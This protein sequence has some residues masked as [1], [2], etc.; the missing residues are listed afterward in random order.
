MSQKK[1]FAT[2]YVVKRLPM[3]KQARWM[4]EMPADG[5]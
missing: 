2:R 3:M 1:W 5:R 4:F